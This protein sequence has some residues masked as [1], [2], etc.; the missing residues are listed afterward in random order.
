MSPRITI[1]EE[2][3]KALQETS[4]GPVFV[5]AESNGEEV[6][7]IRAATYRSLSQGFSI[8]D[9]YEAQENALA[10]IWNEPELDDYNDLAP[11]AS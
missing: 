3:R 11:N 10:S 9:T 2:Q 1:S 4:G 5:L 7:I 6:V 8:A